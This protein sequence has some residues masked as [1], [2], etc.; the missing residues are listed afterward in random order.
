MKLLLLEIGHE[1]RYEKTPAAGA[2]GVIWLVFLLWYVVLDS[3]IILHSSVGDFSHYAP[4]S[5]VVVG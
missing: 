4:L 5:L 3:S 2:T 1:D